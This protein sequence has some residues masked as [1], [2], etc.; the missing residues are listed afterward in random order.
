MKELVRK[1][2][3]STRI[4]ADMLVKESGMLKS[5]RDMLRKRKYAAGTMA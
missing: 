4:M 1:E 3:K 5:Q 2:E